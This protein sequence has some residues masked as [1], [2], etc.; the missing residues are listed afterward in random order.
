MKRWDSTPLPPC[1]AARKA[2]GNAVLARRRAVTRCPELGSAMCATA[3][4]SCLPTQ[5]RDA[6]HLR[7]LLPLPG[8]VV[9]QRPAQHVVVGHDVARVVPHDAGA[10]ALRTVGRQ[11]GAGL[12]RVTHHGMMPYEAA[13]ADQMIMC[14]VSAARMGWLPAGICSCSM[15][16]VNRDS[17]PVIYRE[18]DV[19][20]VHHRVCVL[21]KYVDDGLLPAE[22]NPGMFEIYHHTRS[23]VTAPTAYSMCNN[24]CS[25]VQS[26]AVYLEDRGPAGATVGVTSFNVKAAAEAAGGC[27]MSPAVNAGPSARS[28]TPRSRRDTA[29]DAA[30]VMLGEGSASPGR[31]FADAAL[32]HAVCL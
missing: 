8:P 5:E 13:A 2:G 22:P 29:L 31:R 14:F 19:E 18:R 30:A 16:Q 1:R 25:T 10:V 20:Y 32:R 24:L 3:V 17:Q 6:R 21:L 11:R 7:R 12:R 27:R 15:Q 9:P 23:P 4:M 28:P 26:T